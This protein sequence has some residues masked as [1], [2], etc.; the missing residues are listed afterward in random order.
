ML[1]HRWKRF[2][3]P[4]TLTLD[5]ALCFQQNLFP[6]VTIFVLLFLSAV[7]LWTII[8]NTNI[9]ILMTVLY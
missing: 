6:F 8:Q 9:V 1:Y 5:K 4:A 7:E 2:T 3:I